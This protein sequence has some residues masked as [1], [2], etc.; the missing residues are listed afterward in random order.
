[1][2]ESTI[3]DIDYDTTDVE[4]MPMQ[5]YI[6]VDPCE[7]LFV[8]PCYDDEP[9][10]LVDN[11]GSVDNICNQHSHIARPL[12]YPEVQSDSMGRCGIFYHSILLLFYL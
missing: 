2:E 9:P 4:R 1:M 8:S 5:W 6:Q 12:N 10:P 11:D 7:E 3:I